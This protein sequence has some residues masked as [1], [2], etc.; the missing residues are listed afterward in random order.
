MNKT[1]Q[2]EQTLKDLINQ[3]SLLEI[4]SAL[5]RIC[6]TANSN[7]PDFNWDTDADAIAAM[8]ERVSN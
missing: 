7:N 2:L 1:E 4:M 5:K 3:Y 8:I 6:V